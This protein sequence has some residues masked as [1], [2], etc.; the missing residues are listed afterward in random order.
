M[1]RAIRILSIIKIIAR[2]C[3][4]TNLFPLVSFNPISQRLLISGEVISYREWFLIELNSLA[5]T[6][7]SRWRIYMPVHMA[8]G[9][10]WRLPSRICHTHAARRWSDLTAN[11][12]SET[13][14]RVSHGRQHGQLL[15]ILLQ[16]IVVVRRSHSRSGAS[17]VLGYK[18]E[19]KYLIPRPRDEK[20]LNHRDTPGAQRTILEIEAP[21]RPRA[22]PMFSCKTGIFHI[23]SRLPP[24]RK[25]Y[26]ENRRKQRR[27]G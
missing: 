8:A 19:C 13:T 5:G 22:I 4:S 16:G 2:C 26:G 14:T 23:L 1:T 7:R 24:H 20:S 21:D 10:C 17:A 27:E 18:R 12:S 6:V 9:D 3:L 11:V 25:L 15:R